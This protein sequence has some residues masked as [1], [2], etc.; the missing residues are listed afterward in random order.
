MQIQYK[1]EFQ[2]SDFMFKFNPSKLLSAKTLTSG[3][4]TGLTGWQKQLLTLLGGINYK[5]KVIP[6]KTHK[7]KLELSPSGTTIPLIY[8]T[9]EVAGKVIWS[10]P[11]QEQLASTLYRKHNWLG[12]TI[13]K[14]ETKEIKYY[15]DIVV[16]LAQGTINSLEGLKLNDRS[17]DNITYRF[18]DGTQTTADP[19]LIKIYGE[20]NVP[21]WK[22]KSYLVIENIPLHEYDYSL[23][24]VSASL[25]ALPNHE[26]LLG[27]QL[28]NMVMIPG[29]GEFVYETQVVHNQRVASATSKYYPIGS[30]EY[31]NSHHPGYIGTKS[32]AL[33][34]LDQMKN[35]C[36]NLQWV[37]PVVNWFGTSNK[38]SECSILPGVEHQFDVATKPYSWQVA[39]K[40]RYT[41]YL[42]SGGDKGSPTY[43]GTPA[44]TSVLNLLGELRNRNYKIMFYPMFLMDT[45][46]K[47]WRGRLTGLSEQ[48]HSFFH[49]RGGYRE[50]ILH[51]AELVKGKVDAFLIGSELIGLTTITNGKGIFPAVEELISL[52]KEVRAIMGPEV[53][54]S[55]AADW[56][57]Y[58]HTEGGWHHLD[59]LWAAPEID[60]IGIDAYFPLTN[61]SDLRDAIKAIPNSWEGGEGYEY[62]YN[63]EGKK[64]PISPSQA[65]KNLAYWWS[66]THINPDGKTTSWQPKSKPVWFTECGFPSVNGASNQP[67]LFY[68]PN[69][70]ESGL[71]KHSTGTVDF[72][73]QYQAIKA[74]AEYWNNSEMVEK[75]FWWTWDARPFPTWPERNDI[76]K[77][78]NCWQR[79]HWLNGKINLIPLRNILQDL[80]LRTGFSKEQIVIKGGY[81]LIQGIKFDNNLRST[82]EI[83]AALRKEFGIRF[84]EQGEKIV[85]SAL[86]DYSSVHIPDNKVIKTQYIA[87][88]GLH[89]G[90]DIWNSS[91][92]L[93]Y[94]LGI[95]QVKITPPC[96]GEALKI[97]LMPS[98]RLLLP[99][100]TFTFGASKQLWQVI[101][102]FLGHNFAIEIIANKLPNQALLLQEAN[103]ISKNSS[104][105]YVNHNIELEWYRVRGKHLLHVSPQAT[106]TFGRKLELRFGSESQ[107]L[108][109][110]GIATRGRT[111]T[112]I[113][114]SP[115][116]IITFNN[117]IEIILTSGVLSTESSSKFTYA[118]IGAEI[119]GF[120]SAKTNKPHHYYI[121]GIVRDIGGSFDHLSA[122]PQIASGAKFTLL[123]NWQPIKIKLPH[124]VI[125]LHFQLF[126]QEENLLNTGTF[127]TNHPDEALP[128]VNQ[129]LSYFDGKTWQVQFSVPN[130]CMSS[131]RAGYLDPNLKLELKATSGQS[132][133]LQEYYTE[134]K[135]HLTIPSTAK[136]HDVILAVR[137]VSPGLTSKAMQF[138]L[139]GR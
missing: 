70:S 59:P 1:C 11:V 125:P 46:L 103:P 82:S 71:P 14:T 98:T 52:A 32:N 60:F 68:D 137:L 55:Y 85:I 48:V 86:D 10:S 27:E 67:N 110:P 96:S 37:S 6:A 88:Q 135:V 127:T 25:T 128:V 26:P 15:V 95:G 56:S 129:M 84:S 109:L 33:V 19:L 81:Q 24:K 3:I 22:G 23:P 122:L 45:K 61:T 43:G 34:S 42:I 28:H 100:H 50:F 69:S 92:Q 94:N 131:S 123:D 133:L 38:L 72:S 77:D 111:I 7:L 104:P 21:S 87:E 8:G 51:Y 47:P 57:E 124:T 102:S 17:P 18:Y 139:V 121:S 106:G 130:D 108:L 80:M 53:K 74:T 118:A 9:M 35:T 89:Q 40:N 49:K 31:A 115:R 29:S 101:Q 134:T 65:W 63:H 132:I 76:W 126:D 112:T 116:G 16:L 44:D 138:K 5:T 120:S 99:G 83:I 93:E 64:L 78:G 107:E 62:Y 12:M 13:G 73:W 4:T 20:G 117:E 75:I 119:I 54:L 136:I 90:L 114:S 113:P 58:H 66:N 105:T 39:G 91:T 2:N 41:S 30:A 97:S 36:P 79:G